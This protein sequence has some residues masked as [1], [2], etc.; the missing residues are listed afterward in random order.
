MFDIQ[1]DNDE[2][3]S[4]YR[5]LYHVQIERIEDVHI[6]VERLQVP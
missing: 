4:E 5:W 1:K 2:L 3:C 6:Q